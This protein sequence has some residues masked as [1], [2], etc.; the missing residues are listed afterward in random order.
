MNDQMIQNKIEKAIRDSK[1]YGL[2][3]LLSNGEELQTAVTVTFK[4]KLKE[5][6]YWVA[7]IYQNGRKISL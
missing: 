6:G 5:M 2:C 3:Y 7:C 1:T 4:D